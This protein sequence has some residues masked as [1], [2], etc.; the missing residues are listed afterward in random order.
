MNSQ[1][2]RQEPTGSLIVIDCDR[3]TPKTL[4]D[5]LATGQTPALTVVFRHLERLDPAT[6]EETANLL[7]DLCDKV[8]VAWVVGTVSA[9]VGTPDRSPVR[10]FTTA[11]TVPPVRH[12]VDDLHDLV[13]ALLNRLAPT[14]HVECTADAIR[15]LARNIWPGD[16][17]ELQQVLGAAI[18]HTARLAPSA[19]KISPPHASPSRRVLTPIEAPERDAIIRALACADGNRKRAAA[20]L[21]MSRS[22]LY[23]KIHGQCFSFAHVSERADSVV[24]RRDLANASSATETGSRST[25]TH[26]SCRIDRTAHGSVPGR[27]NG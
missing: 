3:N 23:R 1:G 17:A 2:G 12:R 26:R 25:P 9:G 21:G 14:R 6:I 11:V 16:V 18:R 8:S 13:P 27:F 22:W 20:H 19:A 15:V 24:A 7:D 5:L 4:G 10:H